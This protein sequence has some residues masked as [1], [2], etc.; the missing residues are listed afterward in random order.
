MNWTEIIIITACNLAGI[1]SALALGIS[2][3]EMR[4][5]RQVNRALEQM[6]RERQ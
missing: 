3:G 6:R 5:L 1:L 4:V 2:I